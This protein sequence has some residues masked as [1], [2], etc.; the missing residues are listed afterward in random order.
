MVTQYDRAIALYDEAIALYK[1]LVNREGRPE[2]ADQLATA[3]TSNA[4]HMIARGDGST[5]MIL[6]DGPP[7]MTLYHRAIALCDGAIDLY[8]RLVNDEGR[9]ELAPALAKAYSEKAKTMCALGDI[10]G[11]SWKSRM[12]GVLQVIK[13]PDQGQTF[14]FGKHP[15]AVGRAADQLGVTG[16]CL[17]DPHVSRVHCRIEWEDD[18]VLVS[19]AGSLGGTWING[20]RLTG[21]RYLHPGDVL[22]VGESYL[23][24]RRAHND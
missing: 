3:Y 6:Y 23:E 13:G 21:P 19:D 9:R 10:R 5:A 15:V 16:I 22:V 14:Q 12:F 4:L 2:L 7:A 18:Y 8:E 1:R 17:N 20:E 24:F 11:S